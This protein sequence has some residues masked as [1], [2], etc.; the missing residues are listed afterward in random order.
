MRAR[1]PDARWLLELWRSLLAL[2][3]DDLADLLVDPSPWMRELRQ[4]T[5]FA[6][7]LDAPQRAAV[8]RAFAEKESTAA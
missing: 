3:V 8:Y 7:L 2:P 4:V 5:P 1:H 6:G